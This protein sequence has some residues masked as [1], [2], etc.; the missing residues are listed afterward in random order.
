MKTLLTLVAAVVVLTLH[1]AP[2]SRGSAD[3]PGNA[4]WRA[5][6]TYPA[7]NDPFQPLIEDVYKN[8]APAINPAPVVN[9][10]TNDGK[11]WKTV[12][13]GEEV[14]EGVRI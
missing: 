9:I 12:S 3:S 7:G 11:T 2:I 1:A 14:V 5:A 6:T 4:G 13:G 10:K 8:L